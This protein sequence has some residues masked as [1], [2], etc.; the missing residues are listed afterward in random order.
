MTASPEALRGVSNVKDAATSHIFVVREIMRRVSMENLKLPSSFKSVDD[1]GKYFV[2]LFKMVA[3]EE[4]HVA[5]F[6][7]NMRMIGCVR[8]CQGTV[9][10]APPCMRAIAEEVLKKDASHVVIA[11]NHPGGKLIASPEDAITTRAIS[12]TLHSLGV[13]LIDHILVAEDNYTSI[14]NMGYGL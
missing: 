3:V 6:D 13:R 14:M 5:M 12:T 8:V 11:H 7:N 10:S 2:E 9:N 4:L 1:F